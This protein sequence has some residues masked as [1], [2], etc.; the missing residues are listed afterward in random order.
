MARTKHCCVP[1]GYLLIILNKES[2]HMPHTC[3]SLSS[4]QSAFQSI[5]SNPPQGDQAEVCRKKWFL[6]RFLKNHCVLNTKLSSTW[7]RSVFPHTYPGERGY[8]SECLYL[9][10][11]F[12][13]HPRDVPFIAHVC[14]ILRFWTPWRILIPS[15][16]ISA[17]PMFPHGGGLIF[18]GGKRHDSQFQGLLRVNEGKSSW[19]WPLQLWS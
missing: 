7:T 5:N 17:K 1:K 13:C 18:D 11:A 9:S 19:R 2:N 6:S 3:N 15:V 14:D 10:L 4:P 12:L 8:A 16:S